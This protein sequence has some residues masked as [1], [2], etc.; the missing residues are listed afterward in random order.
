MLY[1]FTGS[2]SLVHFHFVL[3][4]GGGAFLAFGAVVLTEPWC[5]PEDE[6]CRGCDNFLLVVVFDWGGSFPLELLAKSSIGLTL[7]KKIQQIKISCVFKICVLFIA[8]SCF[9]VFTRRIFVEL[10][11]FSILVTISWL[12]LTFLHLTIKSSSNLD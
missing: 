4:R 8:F 9:K 11:G 2:S 6:D 1:S 7:Y 10:F 3:P 12:L 5:S